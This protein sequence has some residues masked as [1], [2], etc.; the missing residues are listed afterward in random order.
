[1]LE[2]AARIME[3]RAMYNRQR[4]AIDSPA[5]ARQLLQMR[6][7]HLEHEE[8]HCLRLDAQ[9]RVLAVESMFRGTLTQTSVYP[10]D[11][12]GGAA[13]QRGRC[14]PVAQPSVRRR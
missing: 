11:R 10:R 2:K 13:S 5:S 1:M 6:L 3:T 4:E 9:H 12:Q 7:G 8:F 14:D